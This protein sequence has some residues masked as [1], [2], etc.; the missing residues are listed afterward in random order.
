MFRVQD[1]HLSI[2]RGKFLGACVNHGTSATSELDSI[3]D[4]TSFVT[5]A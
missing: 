3:L 4:G 5:R 2:T 1:S